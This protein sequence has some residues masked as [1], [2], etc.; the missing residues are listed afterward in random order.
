MALTK[1][2][3]EWIA[4]TVETVM[5]KAVGPILLKQDEHEKTL[6][7]KTGNNGLRS[8]VKYLNRFAWL[9]TGGLILGGAL[10]GAVQFSIF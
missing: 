5:Q 10:L 9:L 2:D 4:L 3:K 8:Q 1:Q 6:Y 7:G